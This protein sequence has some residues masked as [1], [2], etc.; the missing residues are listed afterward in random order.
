MDKNDEKGKKVDQ[1]ENKTNDDSLT[2]EQ[3]NNGSNDF[4]DECDKQNNDS[5]KEKDGIIV[6]PIAG[7]MKECYLAYAMSVIISRAIPDVRDGLKPVH[8]R[9]LYAMNEMGCGYNRQPKKSARIVGE[10]MGKYHPHGDIAIYDSL[11]RMTQDFSMGVPLINGQGNFGSIDNDPPAAMRYT[12]ARLA[13]IAHTMMQDLD[14]E[15]V[16]FAPNYDG[17]ESE[18][19][20]LPVMFPNI[21]VN[22]T[23]GIA[24]GMATNIPPHNMGEIMDACLAYVQNPNITP[25]ELVKIVPGPDFPTG[26]VILSRDL[27]NQ[28]MLTGRCSVPV[29]GK[30]HIEELKGGKEAIIVDEIPYNVVKIEMIKKI[31]ELVK[32][33]KIDGISNIRDE[34]NKHGIRI[35]IEVKKDFSTDIVLNHLYKFT[36]LQSSF[37]VNML[38]LNNNR[39]ELMNLHSIIK[40]FIEFRQEVVARRTLF[41][42]NQARSRAHLLI[43]F[44]VAVDNIDKVIHIIRG[45]DDA[46]QAKQKLMNEVWPA[47]ENVCRLI[48]L[49]SDKNNKVKDGK[50]KFTEVQVKAILEMRLS[51]LTGLERENLSKEICQ[52]SDAIIDYLDTLRNKEKLMGIISS[53]LKQIKEEYAV[54]RRTEILDGEVAEMNVEDFIEK[55]DVL[56]F[57]SAGGYI[58]RTDL[59]SYTAQRRGGKG[60]YGMATLED[61][62]VLKV[63]VANTHSSILFFT[64]NGKVYRIKTYQLPETMPNARG[65]AFVNFIKID[66]GDKLMEL[67]PLPADKNEWS[68]YD[69][70]FA[71]KK[72]NIRRSPMANFEKINS[73]GKI[74]IVLDEDDKLIGVQLAKSTDNI[75]LA[76]KKGMATRFAVSDLRIT[77]GRKSDGVRGM[78]LNGDDEV[79][80]M[81]IL[82]GNENNKDLKEQILQIDKD[83]RLDIKT[84]GINDVEVLAKLN[85]LI[86][87]K[88]KEGKEWN[89]TNEQVQKMINDEQV[90]LTITDDGYGKRTSAYEYRI[91]GRGGKGITNIV[92]DRNDEEKKT[93]SKANVVT[94]LLVDD[95]NDVVMIGTKGKTIR[96]PVK[97]ISVISRKTK[98]V[99]VF[100]LEPGETIASA[101]I[102]YN[103]DDKDDGL[104]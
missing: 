90:L 21:L 75:L 82:Q 80:S 101:S 61:D 84:K 69:I 34:S 18:P 91:T 65:R 42:L 98:G 25:Q 83:L 93:S 58:K 37:G 79:I 102:I 71:T 12:E 72:G 46:Q 7:E 33:K 53:E 67:M 23:E 50:F 64:N 40:A 31:A 97:N 70:I 94:T 99:R 45:S 59:S 3:K 95:T 32:E 57:V 63:F 15:T 74:A 19:L 20:V 4:F 78:R 88:K 55:K 96:T 35:V 2:Q 56:V 26:G 6:T 103:D 10:V 38:V 41:L 47:S 39:P 17:T 81:C 51:K 43:G 1:T 16:D 27:A 92:T 36:K 77:K 86:D 68:K 60:K 9:I 29:R 24:V 44:Y 11:V 54:P 30:T 104:I 87:S 48:D 62:S 22:S 100:N 8:R 76:S 89:L 49:V 14:K 73:N 66:Q 13:K 5:Q 52:L 28:A 85:S